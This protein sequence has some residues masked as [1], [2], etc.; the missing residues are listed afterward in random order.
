[1]SILNIDVYIKYRYLYIYI[2]IKKKLNFEIFLKFGK[3]GYPHFFWG[4]F[5]RLWVNLRLNG[6]T[7]VCKEEQEG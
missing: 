7:R 5:I 6:D 4:N 3:K 1:M 2:R